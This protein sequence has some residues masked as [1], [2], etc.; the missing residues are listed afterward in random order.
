MYLRFTSTVIDEDSRRPRGLFTEAYSLLDSGDLTTDQ[1][2]HL[3]E[4]LDW[5]NRNLPH[6]PKAFVKGRAIFWFR[7]DAHECI[8]KLWEMVELLRANDRHIVVLKCRHLHN[9]TYTDDLQ[10]AAFPHPLDDRIIEH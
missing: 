10:V 7:S 6:P 2:K 9:R 3:R 1:W 8:T 4:L 5:F